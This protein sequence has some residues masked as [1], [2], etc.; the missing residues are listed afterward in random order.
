MTQCDGRY[1][2]DSLRDGGHPLSISAVA[3]LR[4]AIVMRCETTANSGM[5]NIRH[6]VPALSF[7]KMIIAHSTEV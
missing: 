5:H 2:M 3:Q 1:K 7:A 6:H 4:G